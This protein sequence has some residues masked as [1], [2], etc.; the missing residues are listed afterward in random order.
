MARGHGGTPSVW[1]TSLLGLVVA[2]GTSHVAVDAKLARVRHA[3]PSD[4]GPPVVTGPRARGLTIDLGAA[5]GWNRLR[6]PRVERMLTLDACA[7]VAAS[8]GPG[9]GLEGCGSSAWTVSS[10]VTRQV[11]G[12]DGRL[13]QFK[14]LLMHGTSTNGKRICGC[15]GIA[16]SSNIPGRNETRVMY[17]TGRGPIHVYTARR[18][19][20]IPPNVAS[21]RLSACDRPVDL[22][23]VVT[24]DADAYLSAVERM[25]AALV[26][27]GAGRR[28]QE[29][30]LAVHVD[31]EGVLSPGAPLHPAVA[32]RLTVFAAATVTGLR[33][34][35]FAD[36]DLSQE[37]R[38]ARRRG[39][40]AANLLTPDGGFFTMNPGPAKNFTSLL[41]NM[42]Y[43]PATAWQAS[44]SVVGTSH[45]GV[46]LL[47]AV[48]AMASAA[49]HVADAGSATRGRQLRGRALRAH[50]DT[51]TKTLMG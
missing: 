6:N 17:F 50:G 5:P 46:R 27:P 37:G 40:H 25:Y 19:A 28:L 33:A 3:G 21:V 32:A 2:F 30:D 48:S 29:A 49:L 47:W 9:M 10:E 43:V 18:A 42:P 1:V 38:A 4:S 7:A 51:P 12:E 45:A 41:D 36:S 34:A 35:K 14:S 39:A 22:S 20:S 44:A 11:Y 26:Q 15:A 24:D 31:E 13:S 23:P 8:A 16:M